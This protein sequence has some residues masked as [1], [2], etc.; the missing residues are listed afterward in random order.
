MI[1]SHSSTKARIL[2]ISSTK[3]T[4][5]L[6]KKEMRPTTSVMAS[7]ATWPE[8]RTA[9][10]TATAVDSAKATSCTGVAPASCRWYEQMLMGFHLG[11]LAT[12]QA[13]MSVMS[14]IDGSGGNT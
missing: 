5:A 13:I 7:G 1:S 4:P 3:R 14:R 10:S 2:H 11:V 8:S 12:L 6:T 9:S